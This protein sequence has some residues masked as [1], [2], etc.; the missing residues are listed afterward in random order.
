MKSLD[1]YKHLAF[2]FD[3]TLV[4]HRHSEAMWDFIKTNPYGQKFSIVTMRSH[5]MEKWMFH[6]LGQHGSGLTES[7][8]EHVLNVPDEI[9]ATGSNHPSFNG[10]LI[11][12]VADHPYSFWKG[13]VCSEIGADVLIDDMEN[14][15]VSMAGCRRYNIPHIHPDDL[16]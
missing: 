5:G 13:K 8:F 16:L 3:D 7:H 9:F 1:Q 10:G 4:G 11:L 14:G 12:N 15:S 2:D 6:I